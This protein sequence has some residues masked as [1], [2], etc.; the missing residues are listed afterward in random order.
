MSFSILVVLISPSLKVTYNV[1]RFTKNAEAKTKAKN[2][3]TKNKK[4]VVA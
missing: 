3:K 2:N 1:N 4:A